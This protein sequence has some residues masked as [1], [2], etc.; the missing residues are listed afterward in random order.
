MKTHIAINGACGRMG[1]RLVHL[2]LED[3]AL[4]LVA[5]MESDECPHLDRDIGAV[6]GLGALHIPVR[7]YLPPEIKPEV[8]IDF[9]SPD[10][11]MDVLAMCEERKLP[12]VVATTGHTAAQK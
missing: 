10:G 4:K 9:S 6:V 12:L 11:T 8:V 1:Q 5:V 2:A 3:P 7:H